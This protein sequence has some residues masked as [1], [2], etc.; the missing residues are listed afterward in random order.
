MS[1]SAALTNAAGCGVSGDVAADDARGG[2]ESA[3][4]ARAAEAAP[5]AGGSLTLKL[6]GGGRGAGCGVSSSGGKE[7]VVR[8]KV[9]RVRL[10]RL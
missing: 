5:P 10:G 9:G 4:G 2:G 6:P 7:M 8:V 1:L 3:A